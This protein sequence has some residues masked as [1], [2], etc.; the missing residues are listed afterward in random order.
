MGRIIQLP[1]DPRGRRPAPPPR[2]IAQSGDAGL[3]VVAAA[4]WLGLNVISYGALTCAYDLLSGASP[5]LRWSWHPHW[6]AAQTVICT[7]GYLWGWAAEMAGA[8]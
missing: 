1:R 4:I 7:V 3:V 6:F 2:R 8:R 5:W